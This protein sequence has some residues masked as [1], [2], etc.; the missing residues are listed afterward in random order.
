M[1]RLD[2]GLAVA[3]F[4]LD[5][6]QRVGRAAT[7][8]VVVVERSS[9]RVSLHAAR[10]GD[11]PFAQS[12]SVELGRRRSLTRLHGA[13]AGFGQRGTGR[14]GCGAADPPPG[15][16]ESIAVAGDDDG[17]G[18]CEREVDSDGPVAI[19]HDDGTEQRVEQTVH[20]AR[21]AGADV[22]AQRL[23][24]AERQTAPAR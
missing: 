7:R 21:V 17:A 8:A 9:R 10:L 23:A 12:T 14:T 6:G 22:P 24:V 13:L 15:H 2:L 19:D 20:V 18:M 16:A 3:P 11:A 5:A 4:R 1:Q